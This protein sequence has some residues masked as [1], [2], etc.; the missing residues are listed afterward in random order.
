MTSFIREIDERH[1]AATE[2]DLARR[3]TARRAARAALPRE[4][5]R[6]ATL[7]SARP[8]VVAALVNRV[9]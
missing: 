6:R 8:R 9:P 7:L 1:S 2:A 5:R 3:G 4:V